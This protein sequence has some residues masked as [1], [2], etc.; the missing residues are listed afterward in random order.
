MGAAQNSKRVLA[1][2]PLV[3]DNQKLIPNV[4]RVYRKN[5]K[6]YVYFEVYDPATDPKT[7]HL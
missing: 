4:T 3:M 1:A 2:D 7:K 5:Q 6:L